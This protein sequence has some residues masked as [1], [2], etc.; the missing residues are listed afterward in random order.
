MTVLTP[1]AVTVGILAGV[2]GM[3]IFFKRLWKREIKEAE[4]KLLGEN[5]DTLK[6]AA[7][8]QANKEGE[9]AIDASSESDDEDAPSSQMTGE[10]YTYE[11][12]RKEVEGE[13]EVP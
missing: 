2:C 12:I 10:E 4:E 1:F 11:K 8:D 7:T 3:Y 9:R 6:S 5:S 13:D